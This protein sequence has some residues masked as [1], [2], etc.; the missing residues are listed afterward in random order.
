MSNKNEILRTLYRPRLH[1][2]QEDVV[3]QS[4]RFNC[5]ACGRRWG[6][7]LFAG[8]EIAG[9]SAYLGEH[10]G[11]FAP[12]YKILNDA[13]L[14]I[15]HC[16]KGSIAWSNETSRI[17]KFHGKGG[18]I[19]FWSMVDEDAG[20]S[21]KYH[22]V[23]IDEAGM[24]PDLEKRWHESIRPTLVDYRGKA[25]LCGTPKGRNFFW[26]AYT[27]GQ[28]PLK[29]DWASWQ[30]PTSQNPFIHAEEIEAAREMPERSFRQ[31]FL[32]E[33]IEESG[34]VFRSIDKAIEKGCQERFPATTAIYIGVDLA[35]VEDYTVL[36]VVD[37]QGR[38]I[39]HERFNQI[40]WERQIERIKAVAGRF[41]GAQVWLD[42]TGVGDPIFENLRRTGLHVY[43]YRLSNPSKEALIDNLAMMI[44]QG[45][46]GL[47]DIPEQT[48]ELHAYQYEVTRYRNIRMNAP[49]GMHDDCV[50]ALA[51]ACWPLKPGVQFEAS[52][53]AYD[54]FWGIE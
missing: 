37:G 18:T 9:T 47:L 36:C 31:E 12:T 39:Y 10:W 8:L 28:D 50:I 33:F 46:I 16:F 49:L 2:S 24:V 1:P 17:L 35:R 40:S 32:A 42:S 30:M 13:W 20:R 19:E 14:M 29:K 41:S 7:T 11:W 53:E 5:L 22:G 51:L 15:K 38:Q 45:Q 34:G 4:K 44:E 25:W 3:S 52:Q 6:K 26:R 21:R 48:N 27:Y 54:G 23:V 43:G